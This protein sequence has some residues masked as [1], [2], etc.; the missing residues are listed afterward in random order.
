MKLDALKEKKQ[1]MFENECLDIWLKKL[2][3][4]TNLKAYWNCSVQLLRGVSV[5]GNDLWEFPVIAGGN[6]SV[7]PQHQQGTMSRAS[8]TGRWFMPMFLI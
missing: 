2:S 3:R 1:V 7:V 8:T 4:I 6:T 5:V